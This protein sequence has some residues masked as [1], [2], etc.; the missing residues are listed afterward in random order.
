LPA[1]QVKL[2]LIEDRGSDHIID[3]VDFQCSTKTYP[4]PF[5]YRFDT[6]HIKANHNYKLEAALSD[7][8]LLRR[9]SIQNSHLLEAVRAITIQSDTFQIDPTIDTELENYKITVEDFEVKPVKFF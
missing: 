1:T 5:V 9:I 7:R 2:E 6:T 4:C 8:I 3:Q